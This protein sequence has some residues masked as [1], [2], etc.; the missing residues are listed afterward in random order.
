[1]K[2]RHLL[3]LA[4]LMAPAPLVACGDDDDNGDGSGGTA[5]STGGG[6][7]AGTGGGAGSGGSTGG[8]SGSGGDTGGDAGGSAGTG[9]AAPDSGACA[10]TPPDAWSAPDFAA[11]AAGALAL[12]TQLVTL[13]GTD[14]AG[15]RGMERGAVAVG[16]GSANTAAFEAGSP[17]LSDI[18]TSGF[19]PIAVDAFAEFVTAAGAGDQDLVDDGGNW[20]PGAAGGIWSMNDRAINEGGLELRQIIDKALFA[21]GAFYAYALGLTAGTIDAATIDALAAAYGANPT[22]SPGLSSDPEATRNLH[23]ANYAYQM[24]FFADARQ[25]LIDA[26]AY[27]ADAE[28]TAERDAALVTFFRGWEQSM[29]ARF[30]FYAN[31]ASLGVVTATTT[32]PPDDEALAAA[33]HE[34]SEG[35]GLALGFYGLESPTAGPL[36]GAGRTITDAQIVEALGHLGVNPIE[37][38]GNATVGAWVQDSFNFQQAVI[39]VENVIVDVYDLTQANIDAYRT[40]TAG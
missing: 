3:V 36:S 4:G 19:M 29:Y 5:G 9:G 32:T 2:R 10:V 40:P 37:S 30:V 12:R 17:S 28:C 24:G 1:M 31:E 13:M 8:G 26:K 27:A 14:T 35:L 21:G 6:G 18:T 22:L 39:Q 20:A 23:T 16:D 7:S 15:M 33:L 38:L 11:N 25:A 34:L